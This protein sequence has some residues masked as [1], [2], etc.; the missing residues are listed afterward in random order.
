MIIL[1]EIQCKGWEHNRVNSSL[2]RQIIMAFP[3]ETIK[4]YAD[5]EHIKGV[6]GFLSQYG[7]CIESE[8]VEVFDYHYRN[9]ER[10]DEYAVILQNIVADNSEAKC[11][12]LLSCNKGIILA[13]NRICDMFP[14]VSFHLA[15][16][17]ALEE[18]CWE[19]VKIG[20]IK[21][22]Y[23][24]LW[25]IKHRKKHPDNSDAI[26]IKECIE[27]C[28][29]DNCRFII[30]SPCFREE[31]EGL[32]SEK[33]VDRIS[34]IHLAFYDGESK[35][36]GRFD[37]KI[38]I[39]LYGQAVND[40]AYKIINEYNSKYDNGSVL[41]EVVTNSESEILSLRNVKRLGVSGRIPDEELVEYIRSFDYIMVPYD[42]NQYKV[43][44]SGILYDGI[45]YEIPLLM[46][47]SPHLCYYSRYNIG[48]MKGEIEDMAQAISELASERQ[49]RDV[50]GNNERKLKEKALDYNISELLRLLATNEP[51]SNT[52]R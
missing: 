34:F 21:H 26:S 41:F 28:I 19:P 12:F 43:S 17:G 37:D 6:N 7:V 39:G 5:E 32:L 13:M 9:Y 29:A 50:Y 30:F 11:V 3:R 44:V 46:L 24:L 10:A 25:S 15:L 23:R 2:I 14:S 48:L 27:Q 51:L 22:V 18:V 4:L 33:A 31:L 52:V 42:Q 36:N 35:T 8:S 20:L 47:D 38:V 45:S 1:V 40:N 49:M 16:H